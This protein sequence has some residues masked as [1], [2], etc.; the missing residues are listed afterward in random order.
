[1]Q[2]IFESCRLRSNP[3][4]S[5]RRPSSHLRLGFVILEMGHKKGDNLLL[6]EPD[7]TDILEALPKARQNFI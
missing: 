4:S 5:K 1:M 6:L 7:G 3:S 2:E